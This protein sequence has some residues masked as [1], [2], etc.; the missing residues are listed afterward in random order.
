VFARVPQLSRY[1]PVRIKRQSDL[2]LLHPPSVYDFR[3][4]LIIPS[5]IA[6]LVP[7]GTTFEMYP[8]G[9][10]FL[11]E[12]LERYGFKVRVVNLAARMLSEPRLDVERLIAR[13][14]TK[15]FGIGLHW[16]PHAHGAVE[17]AR[18]CKKV[19]PGVP[20]IMGGYSASVFHEEL[21]E[22]PEVDYVVRGD[23][24]EEPLR[25]LLT[26]L[27]RGAGADLSSIPNLT[28]RG[29]SEGEVFSSEMSFVPG[30]LSHL[31]DNYRFMVRSAFRDLDPRGIKAFKSWWSYPLSGVLTVKG[32]TNN[33]TFCGGSASAMS[34]CFN[35]KGL[36]L[37]SPA[38]LADDVSSVASITGAPIFVIG[39][40]R[41]PGPEYASEVLD[42]L[43]RLRVRNHVV[44]E[45]FGPADADFFAAVDDALPNYDIEISPETHDDA[46]RRLAGKPYT[47]G[48]LEGCI[49]A[50]L[51]HGCKKLDVFFMIG[52]EGQTR[53]S[54][55][56]TV[57]YS[58]RLM[59][60]FGPRLNPLIGPLAPFLDPG[61]V[62]RERAGEHGYKVLLNSLE[63]H[64]RALR[65]PH[66][67][68][69]LGYETEWMS[70]QDI[71]DVTYEALLELNRQKSMHGQITSD[72]ADAMDGYL[73]A[74]VALLE[75]LDEALAV[76]EPN[77]REARLVS[78]RSEADSLRER[79]DI[80]KEE[81]QW[82]VV[83]ARFHPGGIAEM[84]L[85]RGRTR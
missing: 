47:A 50:A 30:D 45:L 12:Y 8:V 35:R 10:S 78:I 6:D 23:S 60:E 81:L 53:A 18:L 16:L 73:R 46:L 27:S 56:E 31:G 25:R 62:S 40:I 15:A 3:E 21:M 51:D 77:L 20:V 79:G 11:G 28:W 69:L 48:S 84:L 58:G 13:I 52:I 22:Y 19:Q 57:D 82:P 63:D 1:P 32:C 2:V 71:V 39:D 42:R 59:E 26:A 76:E 14:D 75:R 67:R 83:G 68:D 54:V 33:C 7:S 61:S 44:L 9:F 4:D 85:K 64:R 36:A 43:G 34:S 37:R 24:A 38:D 74:A 55:L 29:N 72:Y 70:R 80:V 66:W 65:Q 17:V 5:P 41:Q 49:R